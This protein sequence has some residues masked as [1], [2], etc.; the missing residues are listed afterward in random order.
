MKSNNKGTIYL[1]GGGNWDKTVTIDTYFLN[2]LPEKKIM[3]L[4]IAKETD[5]NGHF[6]CH[7]WLKSKL[8]KISQKAPDIELELDIYKY[9]NLE[10]FSAIYIGGGNT[11]RLL[12]LVNTSNFTKV[13]RDYIYGGGTVYG[14]SAGAVILGKDISTYA[15]ENR[16]YNY[17][18]SSGLSLVGNYSIR[19]H[20]KDSDKG[21][22]KEYISRKNNPA[23]AV[24]I[25]VA[26][27]VKNSSIFVIG[28][29]PIIVFYS[30]GREEK[31][32][33]GSSVELH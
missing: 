28:S 4:P 6:D 9:K 23:L 24:P 20:Y 1:S 32:F 26:V 21:I 10:Q 7:E 13:L 25:G 29:E 5:L 15:E 8:N 14:A 30:N 22:V 17:P 16:K 2:H 3:F 31:V 18:E 33:P 11:Y 19:C 27:I 12:A